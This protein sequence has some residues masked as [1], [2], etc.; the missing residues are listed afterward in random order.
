MNDA[1]DFWGNSVSVNVTAADTIKK[2]T[3]ES[4]KEI[5]QDNLNRQTPFDPQKQFYPADLFILKGFDIRGQPIKE[6]NP[7]W[8]NPDGFYVRRTKS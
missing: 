1:T 2:V 7:R 6:R 5:K 3:D 8:H 4:W